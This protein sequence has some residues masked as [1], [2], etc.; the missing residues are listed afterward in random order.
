M[1]KTPL[2]SII[3]G[4]LTLLSLLRRKKIETKPYQAAANSTGSQSESLKESS[5]PV[6]LIGQTK[7]AKEAKPTTAHSQK[8]AKPSQ[9]PKRRYMRWQTYF[10][11]VMATL[12]LILAGTAIVQWQTMEKTLRISQRAYVGVNDIQANLEAGQIKVTLENIGHVPAEKVSV[13]VNVQRQVDSDT[14]SLE[15][16]TTEY[17]TVLEQ[18]FP[19]TFKAQILHTMRNFTQ[20]DAALIR[21]GKQRLRLVCSIYYEDD[22]GTSDVAFF[23]FQ[24]SP[25]PN[26]GWTT[27]QPSGDFYDH[28]KTVRTLDK[29]TEE[30]KKNN[31]NEK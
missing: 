23:F 20:E 21:A 16:N 11:G 10:T 18:I 5:P 17:S 13:S 9:K 14:K 28:T 31:S 27:M 19:G 22:F 3:A 7:E 12:T 2:L 26:E 24:Y 6:I 25:P 15:W 8:K 1:R 4:S 30:N 29:L